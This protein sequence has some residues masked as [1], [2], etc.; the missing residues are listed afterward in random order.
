VSGQPR[1]RPSERQPM[2]LSVLALLSVRPRRAPLS[3]QP[4]ELAAPV[5]RTPP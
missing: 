5:D 1:A 2:R 4:R 3:G